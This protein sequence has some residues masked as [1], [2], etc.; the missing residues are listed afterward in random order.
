MAQLAERQVAKFL[1][2]LAGWL[3]SNSISL[4]VLALFGGVTQLRE[5]RVLRFESLAGRAF[6]LF[7]T[8]TL[9]ALN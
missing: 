8:A 7:A 1:H 9:I 5:R 6:F 3:S 2:L 4:L